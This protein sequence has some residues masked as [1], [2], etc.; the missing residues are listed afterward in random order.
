MSSRH[1]R[2]KRSHFK[3]K[4]SKEKR[5]KINKINFFYL[6][7][8]Y[9]SLLVGLGACGLGQNRPAAQPSA[10]PSQKSEGSLSVA[11]IVLEQVD[12]KGQ[13]RWKVNAKQ[14][15]YTKD[16]KIAL[17]T[18][19]DG[20]LFQD[21]KLVYR[22]QAKQGEIQ[23]DGEKIF[24][25]K[26]VTATDVQSG[27]VLRGEELEWRPKED[28]LIVRNNL[29]GTH[30]QLDASAKEGRAFTRSRRMELFGDVVATTKDPVLQLRTEH[31]IWEMEKE[32]AIA[33]RPV[34]ID[35]YNG[36]TI[37]DRATA[38]RGEV[39]LKTK[40]AT[41]TQNAR[42]ALSDPPLDIASEAI[43]WN[44]AAETVSSEQPV[45]VLHRQEQLNFRG[46]RGK[47]D[48]KQ[49]ICYLNGNIVGVELRRQSQL[50]SDRLTWYIPTKYIEAEGNVVY[51]QLD[52]PFNVSGTKAVGKLEDQT[53]VVTN[54][55]GQVRMEIVPEEGQ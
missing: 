11:D 15:D 14:A 9:F 28:I 29:T 21:G 2:G 48:M 5:K 4:K 20:E 37:T 23:Q 35:R 16:Q 17:V 7:P 33:D 30:K 25:K 44:V 8:F 3:S 47:V 26:D 12:E 24:L 36:K 53:V 13:L 40:I 32:L 10:Q 55:S 1:D 50:A 22:I 31:V 39:N 46:D 41:L 38:S 51:Q 52:P 27:A 19:P 54:N 34:Q 18:N 43:A 49:K 6:L 42:L 45:N